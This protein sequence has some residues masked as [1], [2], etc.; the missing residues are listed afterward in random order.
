VGRHLPRPG[1]PPAAGALA[2]SGAGAELPDSRQ[3][4]PAAPDQAGDPRA[5][6]GR[7]EVAG[8]PGP[9]VHQRP[10]GR[11]PAP[12]HIQ[13][14]GDLF[15]ATMR[16]IYKPTR[17][18]ASAPGSSTSPSCCCAPSTCGATTRACWST[19]S[20]ASGT[21]WW[22]SSRTPTPCSTPGCACWRRW[23]QPDGGGRRRP[24]DLRLARRE[25]REHPPVHRDFPDAETIRLE[26]NY[27]STG[28]ILKAANA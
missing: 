15:L 5:G 11:G 17:Q 9:V 8:A 2:G 1:P 3:R 10:E 27:R 21:S 28:G 12:A 20:A 6:P 16:D 14:S 25:N 23:R 18:P 24:V 13:A 4:R 7:T 22:T 26:Q 19:T